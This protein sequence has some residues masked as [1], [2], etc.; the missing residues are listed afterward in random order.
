MGQFFKLI[1][2]RFYTMVILISDTQVSL[3]DRINNFTKVILLIAP[4]SIVLD[5]LN[6]WFKTNKE[7]ATGLIF[8]IFLNMIIGAISHKIIKKFKWNTLLIK[9]CEIVGVTSATYL[10]IEIIIKTAGE[11]TITNLF[12]TTLQ[13]TTLLYPASKILKNLFIISNGKYPPKWV[14]QKVYDFQENGDLSQFL[15]LP[16]KNKVNN[17]K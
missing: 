10:V 14:M 2:L 11:N 5:C 9:T 7:F 16:T 6:L 8:M 15:S 12:E 3:S 4:M 17:K 13:V 1:S